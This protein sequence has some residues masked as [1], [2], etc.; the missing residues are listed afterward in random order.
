MK[1][2]SINYKQK[3]KKMFK[4]RHVE[5]VVKSFKRKKKTKYFVVNFFRILKILKNLFFVI[6]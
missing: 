6:L 5:F 2:Y 1:A 4:F 3:L